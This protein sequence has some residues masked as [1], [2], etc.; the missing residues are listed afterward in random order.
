MLIPAVENAVSG[1]AYRPGDII[2]TRK[3]LTVE[4]TNTDAEGRLVLSD[5]LAEAVQ[6]GPELI[7]DFATLTGAARVALGPEIP[8]F[9]T[10]DEDLAHDLEQCAKRQQ[11]VIWRMPL[12]KPYR[13][14]LDSQIADLSNWL[15]VP[16][17]E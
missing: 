7:I 8:G 6:D 5:A 11:E 12:Y 14:Y 10:A 1:D 17:R 15:S 16:M 4:V 9:F 2:T 13:R 3:G